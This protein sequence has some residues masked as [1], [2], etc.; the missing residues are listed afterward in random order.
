MTKLRLLSRNLLDDLKRLTAEADTI[1]WMTVFLLKSGAKEVLPVLRVAVM[2]G[3]DSVRY[4]APVQFRI[5]Q[6]PGTYYNLV[7]ILTAVLYNNSVPTA[8]SS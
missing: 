8:I 7:A 5:V 1:Y 6:V 3:A 2:R 4:K